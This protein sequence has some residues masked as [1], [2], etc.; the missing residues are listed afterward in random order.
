[1]GWPMPSEVR[2]VRVLV[3]GGVTGLDEINA[4]PKFHCSIG[5]LLR[6]V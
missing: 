2:L 4:R 1:M 3:E 5:N 6:L